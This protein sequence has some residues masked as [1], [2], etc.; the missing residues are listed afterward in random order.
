MPNKKKPTSDRELGGRGRETGRTVTFGVK[1]TPELLKKIR[2]LV[3][4]DGYLLAMDWLEQAVALYEKHYPK[5]R[6]PAQ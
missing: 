6:K 3:D 4:R 5:A 2:S 1:V